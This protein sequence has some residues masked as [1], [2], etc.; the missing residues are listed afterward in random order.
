MLAYLLCSFITVDLP[1]KTHQKVFNTEAIIRKKINCLKQK[2]T[3]NFTHDMTD[4]NLSPK[5]IL[6]TIQN[7]M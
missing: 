5:T 7:R 2:H 3:Q 4:A 1:L 6:E